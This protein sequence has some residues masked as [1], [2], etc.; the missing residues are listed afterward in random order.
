MPS[1]RSRLVALKAA[2]RL[3]VFIGP[4]AVSWCTT[5]SGRAARTAAITAS[6]SSASATTGS[7]PSSRSTAAFSGV[8]VIPVTS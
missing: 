7:A 8:R 1:V 2:S 4:I 3:R 6:R 5:T